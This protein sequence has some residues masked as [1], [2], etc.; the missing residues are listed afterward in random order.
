MPDGGNEGRGCWA[1]CVRVASGQWPPSVGH[2]FSQS[3]SLAGQIKEGHHFGRQPG[4]RADFITKS[5]RLIVANKLRPRLAIRGLKGH[6]APASRLRGVQ[7][8]RAAFGEH[9]FRRWSGLQDGG[10]LRA[11]AVVLV[12]RELFIDFGCSCRANI[13]SK[14]NKTCT[15]KAALRALA[16][17]PSLQ[18]AFVLS[19]RRLGL[20]SAARERGT[21]LPV[22]RRRQ[23][24]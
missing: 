24:G 7:G 17:W 2:R 15:N 3:P 19:G 16:N 23:G 12:E 21:F 4:E 1:S 10:A 18:L 6:C 20:A 13:G 11:L 22:W 5:C 8:E 9:D 14:M